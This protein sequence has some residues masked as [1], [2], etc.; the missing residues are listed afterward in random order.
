[1]MAMVGKSDAEK[2]G[3]GLLIPKKRGS[4]REGGKYVAAY[5]EAGL[6]EYFPLAEWFC[7]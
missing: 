4:G 1:M 3:R 7:G 5:V 2:V 6:D